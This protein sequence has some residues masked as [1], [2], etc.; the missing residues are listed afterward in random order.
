MFPVA[1]EGGCFSA[2]TGGVDLEGNR[3]TELLENGWWVWKMIGGQNIKT[4][5]GY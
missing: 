4:F 2:I 3:W 1:Q 5:I